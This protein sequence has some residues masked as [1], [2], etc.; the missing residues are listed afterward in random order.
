MAKVLEGPGMGLL[1]KW[2]L[3]TP[4]YVVV[5]SS[6][7]FD[8]LAQTNDWLQKSK[9]V[10]KAHEALGSRFKLGL[11]KVGL[12]L[13]GTK[14]AV[15]EML[16]K[17]VESV[18]IREVIVSEAIDHTDEYY[19]AA[20]S[21]REGVEIMV[22]NCGGIEVESNWEK[23]KRI[24]VDIGEEPTDA[25]LSGLVKDAG[26]SGDTAKKVAEFLKKLFI[27]FDNEDAQYLE[28]NPV[29]QNSAGDLV[30]LDAVTLLDGD[31]KFR[32]KDWTFPFAAEFGRAYT[33]NEEEVM[34]VDAKVK[35]SVK[36]IEIPG[37]NIAMLPAGGGASVYYSDAVVARG[38]KLANYAE[39]S[40]DPPDWAVEV[41]TEKV[42]SL[43]G[44]TNI[45]VGGAIANFTDVKKTFGGII[46][47]FR[48]AKAEGKMDNVRIW[49]RR[50]GPNEKQGLAAMKELQKE[51][52]KI[53]VF[54]R[55]LPLTDIVDMALS[56]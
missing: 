17:K 5:S 16:G 22:A 41:L 26:F 33:K 3:Q 53:E 44:I 21:V 49:V 10:A 51:G 2:G 43:P 31:A 1:K 34:A 11:V 56:K 36:L 48:K 9:L 39:Y 52:F 27:C 8:Q 35:G 32:H 47:A 18:T 37:G 38:G 45:I 30:A 54:D 50:G 42:C 12:D 7:E 4:N 23:V 14:A 15:K 29:V 28:I 55:T 40:G 6:E 25:A 46:N 24:L 13:K 20:K 19:A